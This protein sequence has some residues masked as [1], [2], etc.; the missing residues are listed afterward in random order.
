MFIVFDSNVWI[1]QVGLQSKKGAAVRHFAKR[2][3]AIVAIPEIVQLE[4]EEK[5]TQSLLKL[6]NTTEDS[7][8]QLLPY[9]RK[10]HPIHLPSEEELRKA[11]ANIIPTFDIPTR[12]LPFNVHVARSSMMKVIRKIP[13][14][15]DKREEF[16]DGVIW[17][18]CLELLDEGD[19][20]LVTEDQDFYDERNYTKG[21]ASELADELKERSETRQVK[22]VPHLKDLL[23]EIRVPF[24]PDTTQIF[25]AIKT[26][27]GKVVTEL[28]TSHEFDLYGSIE[29]KV[30][31]FATEDAQ[32]VYFDFSFTQPCRDATESKRRDGKLQF[33]DSAFWIRT[34]GK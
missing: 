13:P 34:R 14:S 3:G 2:H 11:V 10:L 32:R 5:L 12:H 19:V 25:N 1:D 29:G 8:L 23:E 17:A 20:Y 27:R 9:M 24:E 22:L 16:R 21:L 6:R 18:H 7:Y 26:Q 15:T 33:K 28:L 31:C 30:D 4:V